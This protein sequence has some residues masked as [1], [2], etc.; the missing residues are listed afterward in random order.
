MQ[1]FQV[2]FFWYE[3]CN[4]TVCILEFLNLLSLPSLSQ[5]AK[6]HKPTSYS[7]F[8]QQV[9]AELCLQLH[10]S[11][12]AMCFACGLFIL[13]GVIPFPLAFIS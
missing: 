7:L 10:F 12:F 13:R 8:C 5:N 9:E 3:M 1:V 4:G 2:S 6:Y 11:W